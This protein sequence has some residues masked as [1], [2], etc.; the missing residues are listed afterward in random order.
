MVLAST[1]IAFEIDV[2]SG[3][4]TFIDQTNIDVYA[5]AETA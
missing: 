4:R 3:N 2:I 5:L 1:T